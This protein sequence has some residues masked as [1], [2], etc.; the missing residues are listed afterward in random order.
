MSQT[1]ILL[2]S[3]WLLFPIGQAPLFMGECLK[4]KREEK[5]PLAP[6]LTENSPKGSAFQPHC[7]S[8]AGFCSVLGDV[9]DFSASVLLI[10]VY[11]RQHDCL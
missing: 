1:R 11:P 3:V 4:P 6:E 8:L 5:K 9:P 10:P 2:T 7:L